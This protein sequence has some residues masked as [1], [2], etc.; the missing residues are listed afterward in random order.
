MNVNVA[1]VN[2]IYFYNIAFK[3]TR[4]I[5]RSRN[6]ILQSINIMSAT[7]DKIPQV[8]KDNFASHNTEPRMYT[9]NLANSGAK[10]N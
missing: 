5:P 2:K 9:P 1:L 4:I 8:N 3:T 6:M 7:I 10:L